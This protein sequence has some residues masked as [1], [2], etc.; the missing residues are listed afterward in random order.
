MKM[1]FSW[2]FNKSKNWINILNT[3]YSSS[4]SYFPGCQIHTCTSISQKDRLCS[5][6]PKKTAPRGRD[7][8]EQHHHEM[9]YE[10]LPQTIFWTYLNIIKFL[11]P[12]KNRW[13]SNDLQLH[14]WKHTTH[15][16]SSAISSVFRRK[17]SP[18]ATDGD[19][20]A[21]ESCGAGGAHAVELWVARWFASVRGSVRWAILVVLV[22]WKP[23]DFHGFSHG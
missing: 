17:T 9:V 16:P 10:M 5:Q 13:I 7:L 4:F 14:R 23:I 6:I 1:G 11:M 21:G 20:V 3:P 22:G 8:I 2:I 19:P 18:A 12:A 15:R